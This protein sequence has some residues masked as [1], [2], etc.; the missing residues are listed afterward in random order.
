ML[1][2]LFSQKTFCK[3]VHRISKLKFYGQVFLILTLLSILFDKCN[4][5]FIAFSQSWVF[6]TFW[7]QF[8]G[9]LQLL[10]LRVGVNLLFTLWQ[11]CYFKILYRM[12]YFRF[13]YLKFMTLRVHEASEQKRKFVV[14]F[15]F[16]LESYLVVGIFHGSF[17]CRSFVL[18]GIG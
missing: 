2:Q 4:W 11:C 1:F 17:K 8:Y 7:D 6:F 14:K 13:C 9:Y 12:M 15:F 10:L 18:D 3:F 16:D 5:Y